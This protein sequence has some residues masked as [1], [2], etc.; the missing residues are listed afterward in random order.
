MADL[1]QTS[2]LSLFAKKDRRPI[3]EWATENLTQLPPVLTVRS[4]SVEESRHFCAPLDALQCEETRQVVIRKPV[5]SGGT[6]IADVWHIWCRANDPGPAMSIFQSDKIAAD[7]GEHRLLW[8][9]RRCDVIKPL[10]SVDRFAIRKNEITFA[11]GLPLY[12]IGPGINN[13]QTRGIRYLSISEA[14]IPAVGAMV[15]QAEGRL[16]DF[17]RVQLSKLLLDSQGGT[18]GDPVDARFMDGNAAEWNV[19]CQSCGHHMPAK[20]SGQRADGTRWGLRWNEHK[21]K[22]GFWDLAACLPT[23]RFECRACGHPHLDNPQ[24]RARWNR[25]GRFIDGNPAAPLALRSY[26]WTGLIIDPWA[27]LLQTFLGAM[28]AYKLGVIDPLVQF[29]QKYMGEPKSE[30]SVHETLSNVPVARYEVQTTWPDEKLRTL[31]VDVQETEFWYV[32]RAWGLHGESRRLDCG[33]CYNWTEL[34][35]LQKNR[36][37]E[38]RHVFIDSG[39]RT[40]EVYRACCRHGAWAR[41]GGIY[42]WCGWHPVKGEPQRAFPHKWKKETIWRS[43][44]EPTNVDAESGQATDAGPRHCQ[45]IRFS[46]PTLQDRLEQLLKKGFLKSPEGHGEMDETY[47][48]HI[49]NEFKRLKKNKNTGRSEWQY[50]A[51]GPNHMRDC[52]KISVLGATLSELLPD[53]IDA[54]ANP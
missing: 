29:F 35:L 26:T 47:K 3:Y 32:I 25:S 2:L 22:R 38:D 48:R 27:N 44:S 19:E 21:D 54:E 45:L 40:K 41:M 50:V 39:F 6:L 7:H 20:W 16:G 17:K 18:E 8:M 34:E 46:D 43:Y 10:L 23:V 14:W 13:L 28:N 11:D 12:V 30:G 53:T 49:A 1:I 51:R 15:E 24:T 42:V 5:R 36:T 33:R 31:C 52:E 37:I 9:M 4:F